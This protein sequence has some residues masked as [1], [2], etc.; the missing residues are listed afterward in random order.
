MPYITFVSS[1]QPGDTIFNEE[2]DQW[3]KKMSEY[4]FGLIGP[5]LSS[6]IHFANIY[7]SYFR[8]DDDQE[9]ALINRHAILHGSINNF[10]SQVNAVKLFTFLYLML[11]LEP[12]F[13]ILFA[14]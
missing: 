1:R 6:F 7:Y 9:L 2:R 4:D 12:V 10:G 8:E 11:E 5:A 14:E 13:E 3:F